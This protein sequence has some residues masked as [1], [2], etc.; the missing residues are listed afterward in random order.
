MLRGGGQEKIAEMSR[1]KML[2]GGGGGRA[3]NLR[4]GVFLLDLIINT[5]AH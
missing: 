1:L 2:F 4:G 3:I 5:A